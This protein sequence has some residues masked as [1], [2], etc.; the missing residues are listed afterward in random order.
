MK[1][2]VLFIFLGAIFFVSCKD[3]IDAPDVSGIE[4]HTNLL[5]FEQD[6]FALDT[7]NIEASLDEVQKKYPQFLN[8]F[9]FQ[10][11]NCD[12]NKDSI[13]RQV[14]SF[15]QSYQPL[16]EASQ[17]MYPSFKKQQNDIEQALKYVHY[18]F[19]AYPLPQNIITYVAPVES[20]ACVL[21]QDGPGIGLQLALGDTSIFYSN[22][23]FDELYPQY[24]QHRFKPEYITVNCMKNICNDI[25]PEQLKDAPL[26]YQMIEA[27]KTL[28][29][30]D[31]F[32]PFT[33]DSLKTGYT[34][35]Q[36]EG[37][38]D[39]EAAIWNYFLQNNLLFITDPLQVRDYME[40]GPKT[41]MLGNGSPGFIGQFV[42]RQIIRKWLEANSKITL[43]DLL[44]T[45]AK[46]IYEEAKYKPK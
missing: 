5:R 13:T 11:L 39:N 30:L 44:K 9:L 24:Q 20:Y 1:K 8:D 15:L 27:G 3:K 45:P 2:T 40:D 6:F 43:D 10:M 33:A 23:Y 19:P 28:Y 31:K 35:K 32:L 22:D 18:Y 17:K 29:M 25:Y 41:E 38:F 34:K 7:N 42:G 14:K 37:C 16:Y 21:T 26:V 46:K 12:T 36:L 4:V